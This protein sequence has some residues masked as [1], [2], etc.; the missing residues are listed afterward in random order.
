MARYDT[1]GYDLLFQLS[2][3]EFNDRLAALFAQ[4][5]GRVPQETRREFDSMGFQGDFKF[6]FDTPWVD[7]SE[8]PS[9]D[10]IVDQYDWNGADL[11]VSDTDTITLFIPFSEA[12]IRTDGGD[13]E[14]SNID[15]CILVQQSLEVYEAPDPPD[16]KG[17]YFDIGLDFT[18]PDNP[19]RSPQQCDPTEIDGVETIHVG[20]TPRTVTR[21]TDVPPVPLVEPVRNNVELETE[22]LFE[23]AVQHRAII[24]Q[25]IE[26]APGS[27]NPLTAT[28]LE[29][30]VLGGTGSNAIAVLMP[31]L[32]DSTGHRSR[33]DEVHVTE[34]EP[35][36]VLIDTATLI[37]EFV[38]PPIADSIGLQESEFDS[39]SPCR[40]RGRHELPVENE[41][42]DELYLTELNVAGA[43]GHLEVTGSF[44]GSGQKVVPYNISGTF[45]IVV[46]LSLDG[47]EIAVDVDMKEPEV[48]LDFNDGVL[49]AVHVLSL[50]TL[51]V[52]G[53]IG[54]AILVTIADQGLENMASNIAG[55][56]LGRRLSNIGE[57][58]IPLAAAADSFE[59]TG[60]TLTDEALVLTGQPTHQAHVPVQT[61][62]TTVH[63]SAV[64]VDLDTG[65]VYQAR[66]S[67]PDGVDITLPGRPED[68]I[69]AHSSAHLQ[70]LSPPVEL[71]EVGWYRGLSPV[72]LEQVTFEGSPYIGAIPG[73][74]IPGRQVP[75]IGDAL[76]FAVRTSENR[77]TKCLVWWQEEGLHWPGGLHFEYVTYD[78]P[79]PEI[80]FGFETEFPRKEEIESGTENWGT[81]SC[82]P[83][84]RVNGEVYGGGL[85]TERGEAEYTIYKVSRRVTVTATPKLL[86]FPLADVEWRLDGQVLDGQGTVTVDG[87]DVDYAVQQSGIEP[88]IELTTEFGKD[89]FADLCVTMLD[90]RGIR[91][92]TCYQFTLDRRHKTGGQPPI[93]PA[94]INEE[95]ARCLGGPVSTQP[96]LPIEED[97]WWGNARPDPPPPSGPY[98]P[99]GPLFGSGPLPDWVWENVEGLSPASTGDGATPATSDDAIPVAEQEVLTPRTDLRLALERGMDLDLSGQRFR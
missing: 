59:F 36:A 76:V 46:S 27:D 4:G 57:D 21:L 81:V 52:V 94:E 11:S 73:T 14:L 37:S 95:I 87:H 75:G 53:V 43:D 31:T 23:C 80:E 68:D 20:F 61:A 35:A 86:A 62:S 17:E 2:E 29:V 56:S 50:V 66:G 99:V 22:R 88:T 89:L 82:H 71:F 70:L 5:G 60:L 18:D 98:D 85:E 45:E 38:C 92:E 16:E 34:A 69:T 77:Y 48:N 13:I 8:D 79:T 10:P 78:R 12:W 26:V 47:N 9:T 83:S 7:L 63:P 93:A 42:V 30:K 1:H 39:G 84:V 15:G 96:V 51:G 58:G 49:V 32:P 64:A 44:T 72:D 28:D 65:E 54:S 74:R 55:E 91:E 67:P 24:P 19:V 40:F 25:S 97:P 90:D 3:A 6:L 33:I 41:Y